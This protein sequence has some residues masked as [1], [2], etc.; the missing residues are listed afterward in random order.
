MVTFETT[1]ENDVKKKETALVTMPWEGASGKFP[2][3]IYNHKDIAYDKLL[4]SKSKICSSDNYVLSSWES[5]EFP[6]V[7]DVISNFIG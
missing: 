4:P 7:K 2:T 1:H 6:R 3:I 5:M